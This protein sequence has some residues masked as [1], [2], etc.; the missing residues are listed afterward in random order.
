MQKINA[1]N[2]SHVYS[3]ELYIEKIALRLF[4][5]NYMFD[6][7]HTRLTWWNTIR[8]YATHCAK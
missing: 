5:R 8:I 6:G 7:D 3:K 2:N 1:I 4:Y